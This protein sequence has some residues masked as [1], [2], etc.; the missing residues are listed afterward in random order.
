MTQK[1]YGLLSRPKFKEN[2]KALH[3][4]IFV[5]YNFDHKYYNLKGP[6]GSPYDIL[7]KKSLL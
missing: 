6:I 5:N 1:N 4:Y 7:W 3:Y 2:G